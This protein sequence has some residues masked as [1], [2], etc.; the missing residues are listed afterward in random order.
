MPSD[1]KPPRQTEI[2]LRLGSIFSLSATYRGLCAFR[3][4]WFM[5]LIVTCILC[6]TITAVV[7]SQPDVLEAAYGN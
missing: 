6:L 3:Q 7:L 4:I 5:I 1:I 2:E